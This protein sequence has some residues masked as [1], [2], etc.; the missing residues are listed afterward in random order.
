MKTSA[1][2]IAAAALLGA[3]SLSTL[4][5]AEPDNHS[6]DI[7]AAVRPMMQDPE[8]AQ[9]D[10]IEQCAGCHG[11]RGSTVP[12]HLPEIKDRVG[13]FMCTPESRAYLLRLPNVAHSRLTDNAQLADLMNYVVFVLGGKS[14][15]AGTKPFTADEVT[16][17]RQFPLT[18]G[19]LAAERLRL[20]NEAIRKCRAPASLRLQFPGSAQ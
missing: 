3:L 11:V 10:F 17:E 18:S 14:A 8:L 9:S 19:S 16:R 13:W 15:P 20:A 5:A 2:L 12:A 6:P 4:R 1:V 7:P